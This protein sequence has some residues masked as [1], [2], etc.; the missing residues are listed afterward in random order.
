MSTSKKVRF[1]ALGAVIAALYAVL[2][3]V[4]A[5]VNLAYGPVQFRFSEA[6]TVLP[7]F[8]PAAIP[9]LTLGCVIANLGS[10]L[11]W[12][13]GFSVPLPPCW[14]LWPPIW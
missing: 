11:A 1:L 2:T 4:A 13:T 14:L 8:T 3:Y 5:A 12:W 9:G 10:P 7:V 6:L